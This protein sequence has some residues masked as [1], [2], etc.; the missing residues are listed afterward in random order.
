[1]CTFG[2]Q[3]MFEYNFEINKGAK[4]SSIIAIIVIALVAAAVFAFSLYVKYLS[5]LE[6]GAKYVSVFFTNMGVKA[7]AHIASFLLIF[8][9]FYA[10]TFAVDKISRPKMSYMPL[11][12]NPFMMI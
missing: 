3:F 5:L 11:K 8:V 7:I 10:S 9:L 2:G 1:M 4:K 12:T 6:I